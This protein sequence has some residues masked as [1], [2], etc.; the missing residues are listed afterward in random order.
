MKKVF[1]V[2]LCFFIIL[3]IIDDSKNNKKAELENSVIDIEIEN[4]IVSKLNDDKDN[5][6]NITKDRIIDEDNI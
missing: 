3:V 6:E 5:E 4:E 1:L 2:I